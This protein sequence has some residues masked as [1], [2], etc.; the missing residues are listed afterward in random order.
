MN[1]GYIKVHKHDLLNIK[2]WVSKQ[3]VNTGDD[4]L[5]WIH[6]E[7]IVNTTAMKITCLEEAIPRKRLRY[8]RIVLF[9][10][11]DAIFSTSH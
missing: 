1:A 3:T 11:F 7:Q 4:V 10:W 6:D 8:I 2:T 9:S 5:C